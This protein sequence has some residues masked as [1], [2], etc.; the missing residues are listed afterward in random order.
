M[1]HQ[2]VWLPAALDD[3]EAIAA[4]IA[5]DSPAYASAVVARVLEL[6]REAGQFP[7]AGRRLPE[8]DG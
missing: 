5:G 1:A 2:V 7:L 8:W 6:A 4:Y 3:L